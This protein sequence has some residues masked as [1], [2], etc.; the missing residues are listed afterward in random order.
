MAPQVVPVMQAPEQHSPLAP[1]VPDVHWSF[2]VHEPLLLL[3]TH[4][5][6][7]LQ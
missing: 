1:Q 5:P 4:A 7:L 3:G 2:V 6:L